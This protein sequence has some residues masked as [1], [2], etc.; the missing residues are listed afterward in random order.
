MAV[1]ATLL[2]APQALAYTV[3]YVDTARLF[4]EAKSIKQAQ[5]SV[6][7]EQ[8]RL[9]K[10]FEAR[11]QKLE[12]ARKTKK[13]ADI[14]KLQAQYTKELG[15]MRDRMQRLDASLSQK[16]KKQVEASIRGIAARRKLDM[17]L[18]KQVVYY[19]GLDITSD[20]IRSLNK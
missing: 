8:Q 14:Q 2:M 9:Q 13:D 5:A 16:V 18:D 20:V 7:R 6:Q 12:S 11:Q 17:V 19:G 1:A 15:A 10:E 4:R 3:G